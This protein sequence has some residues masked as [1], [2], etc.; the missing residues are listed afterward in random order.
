MQRGLVQYSI[1]FIFIFAVSAMAESYK[2]DMTHSSIKFKIRCMMIGNVTGKFEQFSGYFNQENGKISL[3]VAECHTSSINT[4]NSKRDRDLKSVNFFNSI[5]FPKMT[6]KM[7]SAK[8]NT[9]LIN[10][11]IKG[12]TKKVSFH[13][14]PKKR[15]SVTD[16]NKR[17]SFILSGQVYLKDFKLNLDKTV[18]KKSIVLGKKVK[19]IADIEGVEISSPIENFFLDLFR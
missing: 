12:I 10:L 2:V 15:K 13:Y 18:G 14:L 6:M 17:T 19:I 9:V 16:S 11:T 5:S 3:F 8:K 4:G 1:L 7:I